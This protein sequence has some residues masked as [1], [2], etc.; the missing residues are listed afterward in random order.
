MLS[1][2][3]WRKACRNERSP[4]VDERSTPVANARIEVWHCSPEGFYEN[5][6]PAQA[7]MNLRGTFITDEWGRIASC[8][9]A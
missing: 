8:N 9:S 6:D 2:S 5:Q 7:D 3:Y 4:T 1:K